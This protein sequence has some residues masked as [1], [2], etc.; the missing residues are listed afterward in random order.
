M[1]E[2]VAAEFGRC[3]QAVP[4]PFRCN[5]YSIE[6]QRVLVHLDGEGRNV[7][8]HYEVQFPVN[9]AETGENEPVGP[10]ADIREDETP[11]VIGGG[12]YSGIFEIDS[13][14]GDYFSCT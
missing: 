13:D 4:V 11:V 12:P 3:I 6:G 1:L 8:L 14:S 5:C 10:R 7:G 2:G 9:V